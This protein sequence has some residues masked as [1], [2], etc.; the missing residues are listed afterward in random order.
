VVGEPGS[1]VRVGAGSWYEA[2]SLGERLL[3][4][5]RGEVDARRL[6]KEDNDLPAA[7]IDLGGCC[8][9]P[10]PSQPRPAVG[11]PAEARTVRVTQPKTKKSGR[12]RPK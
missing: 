2:R 6:A 3:G 4:K 7:G 1:S 11:P 5:P 9:A 12:T 8:D 10:G